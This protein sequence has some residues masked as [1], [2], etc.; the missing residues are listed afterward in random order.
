MKGIQ[1]LPK[2]EDI[3]C[4]FDNVWDLKENSTSFR[5]VVEKKPGNNPKLCNS[6][7]ENEYNICYYISYQ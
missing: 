6:T 7:L 2:A 1:Y 3:V 5:C 4:L